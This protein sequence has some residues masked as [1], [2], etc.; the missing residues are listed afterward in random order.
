MASD[1]RSKTLT[2]VHLTPG[3]LKK[4]ADPD[5]THFTVTFTQ[6]ANYSLPLT[7][8]VISE[9]QKAKDKGMKFKH[10]KITD[11]IRK[12]F[13]SGGC[14][15]DSQKKKLEK[16]GGEQLTPAQVATVQKLN[17]VLGYQ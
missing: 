11:A 3:S 10:F 1:S 12:H 15:C 5:E 4:L 9:L 8:T 6:A 2:P 16:V 7:A 13:A 14:L 17:K